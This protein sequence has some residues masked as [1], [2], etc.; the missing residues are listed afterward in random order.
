MDQHESIPKVPTGCC[1]QGYEKGLPVESTSKVV[2]GWVSL[3]DM[4]RP[5]IQL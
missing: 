5:P 4:Q 3:C 2:R 1:L